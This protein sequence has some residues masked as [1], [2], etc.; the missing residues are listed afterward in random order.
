MQ[1]DLLKTKE[2]NMLVAV[3]YQGN[4]GEATKIVDVFS[5]HNS[6]SGSEPVSVSGNVFKALDA[7]SF[8]LQ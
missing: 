4:C 8:F 7:A 2:M 1:I 6:F 3:T 5:K